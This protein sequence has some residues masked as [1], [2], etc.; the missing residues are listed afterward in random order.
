MH[1]AAMIAMIRRKYE[2][3]GPVLDERSRRRWAATEARELGWGGISAV[4]VATGLARDTI[5]AGLAEL[6]QEQA[7]T[8]RLPDLRLRRPGGGRKPLTQ[9]D[10]GLARALD[11][12]VDP[13][14]R[15]HPESP[16]RWTCKS[17]RRLAAELTR[18]GHALS[19]NTVAALLR[20]EGYSLQANRKTRE[21]R[22]HPDR[23][24]QFAYLNGACRPSSGP[25]S[26]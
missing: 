7:Q 25:A 6:R 19:P 3:L 12:L 2:V 24:A 22:Q 16:L 17:T 10:P 11:R 18:Q 13:L 5:H 15:G 20:A 14:T 4:A 8:P 23:D 1:A 26:R 21:G 9:T